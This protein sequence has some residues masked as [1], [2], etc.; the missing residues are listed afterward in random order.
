MGKDLCSHIGE[1]HHF[2]VDSGRSILYGVCESCYR[3]KQGTGA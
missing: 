3:K 1:H 2:T